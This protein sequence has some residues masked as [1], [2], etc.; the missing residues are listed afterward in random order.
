VTE[1]DPIVASVPA[2]PGWRP[3]RLKNWLALND[4]GSW[5]DDPSNGGTRVLRSTN[6]DEGGGWWLEDI[7]RR[8]LEPAEEIRTRLLPG[9][10]LVVKSSGSSAHLGKA[11]HVDRGLAELNPSFSN[12][13]Q[14][15]RVAPP[16]ESRYLFYL[17]NSQYGRE[18]MNY[19]GSTTTGLRNL[20]AEVLGN[21]TTP[22]P[23][24]SLQITIADFLDAETAHVDQLLMKR[25]EQ[26]EL[27]Q[28]RFLSDVNGMVRGVAVAGPRAPASDWVESMP[29]SWQQRKVGWDY[30]VQLGKMLNED[31]AAGPH[32]RPYLRNANVQWDRIDLTDVAEMSFDADDR[33]RFALL[34]GDLLVCEGGE[35]GRAALWHGEIAD[36]FYQKAIHRLRPYGEA[37]PRFLLYA[38]WAAAKQGVF[39]LEGNQSTIVH[40]T[41]EKLRS[42]RL[43]FPLVQEQAT[44]VGYLDRAKVRHDETSAAVNRQIELLRERRAALITAAVTGQI[45]VPA[46]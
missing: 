37:N 2:T 45:E 40:L 22:G 21:L 34:P 20:N 19:M 39:A 23:P 15:L 16:H 8:E 1:V 13:V 31:A 38:L 9:D 46:A 17:L 4:S 36:C 33:A 26:L 14:R 7:A 42:H 12:F 35:V 25:Q 24:S 41:A 5:G 44:I 43:P 11:A 30:E 28:E 18:Y 6:I 3:V 27:I 10:V 29:A 32:P